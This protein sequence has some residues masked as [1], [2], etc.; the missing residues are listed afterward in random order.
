[1][2]RYIYKIKTIRKI[3]RKKN[4]KMPPYNLF[5]MAAEYYLAEAS[6]EHSQDISDIIELMVMESDDEPL[7]C[8]S[9][10]IPCKLFA[11]VYKTLLYKTYKYDLLYMAAYHGKLNVIEWLNKQDIDIIDSDECWSLLCA[12]QG[13]HLDIVK[14]LDDNGADLEVRDYRPMFYA[15]MNGHLD[16]VRYLYEKTKT[17]VGDQL[18]PAEEACE[19]GHTEVVKFLVENG[20]TIKKYGIDLASIASQKGNL[21][22]VKYLIE[23]DIEHEISDKNFI[24]PAIQHGHIDI[25][26]YV[27]ESGSTYHQRNHNSI[28]YAIKYN[29]PDIVKYLYSVDAKLMPDYSLFYAIKSDNYSLAKRILE[30]ME[31]EELESRKKRTITYHN[32]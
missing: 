20:T 19:F 15:A 1:L 8:L 3:F 18:V 21:E 2:K 10:I 11:N 6:R 9:L 27:I 31:K 7:N 14:Y 22:L 23:K 13:G 26:K 4:K 28:E 24:L 25:V 32:H 12:A 16:V 5:T 17:T 30:N 29:Q